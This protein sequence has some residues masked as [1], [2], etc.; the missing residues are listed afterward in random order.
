MRK[1]ARTAL[2]RIR[3]FR[4]RRLHGGLI[5]LYHRIASAEADPFRL[6]VSP[7]HFGEHLRALREAGRPVRLHELVDDLKAGALRPRS[8]A[9]TF[10][11]GYSDNLH[12]ALPLLAGADI[13]A[14]VFA[15]AGGPGEEFWW[16]R[17]ARLLARRPEHG[18]RGAA[19]LRRLHRRLAPLPPEERAAAIDGLGG[20]G[21]DGPAHRA[22][23][24]EELRALADS[25]LVEI[26]AH[27]RSHP[28]LDAV[29]A[30]RRAREITD[31]GAALEA[32]LGRPVRAFSYPHGAVS[33]AVVRDVRAAGYACACGTHA[34][35][36]WGRSDPHRLP[37]LWVPDVD[38]DGLLRLLHGWLGAA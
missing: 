29:D 3:R 34:D 5:L 10:D 31:G 18:P 2:R 32:T 24:V 16:D 13:P 28:P 33:R 27:T 25:P 37:R 7:D 11:D 6:S 17:L 1:A 30:S 14:T 20:E 9:V 21:G 23:T 8:V 15:V 22:L 38:G 36:V 35:V 26:G 19:R 12:T 4:S